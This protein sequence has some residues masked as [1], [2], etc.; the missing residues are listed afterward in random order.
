MATKK[1]TKPATAKATAK[2]AV[3]APAKKATACACA[4]PSKKSATPKATR[5]TF[6]VRAEV[7]SKVFL[8]GSFNGWSPTAKPMV[9]KTGKGEFT[10]ALNLP[11]GKYEYKFVINGSWCADPECAEWVQNDMGTLNSVK[12]VD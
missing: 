7:G 8:A 10:C 4:C 11:K 3:K 5:V 9:D 6:H 1:T 12:I 2:K